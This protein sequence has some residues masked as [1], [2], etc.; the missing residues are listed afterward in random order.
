MII[1]RPKQEERTVKFKELPVGAGF[2]WQRWYYIKT[3]DCQ[4]I[5][6][7]D[8]EKRHCN[9]VQLETGLLA[10]FLNCGLVEKIPMSI[11]VLE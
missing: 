10:C 3:E 8:S 11:E 2:R 9:A 1:N 5:V 7:K 6:G 4:H